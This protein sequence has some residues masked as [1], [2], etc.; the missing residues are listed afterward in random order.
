MKT[1]TSGMG[2]YALLA[3]FEFA[4]PAPEHVKHCSTAQAWSSG[5]RWPFAPEVRALDAEVTPEEQAWLR[6][7][8]VKLGSFS[9][10]RAN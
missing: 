4:F 6:H 3:K 10:K 9:E 1:A 5:E 8:S 7:A 2:G